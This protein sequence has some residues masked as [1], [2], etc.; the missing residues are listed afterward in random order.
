MTTKTKIHWWY[1][2]DKILIKWHKLLV[3]T[4]GENSS[5]FKKMIKKV[6]YSLPVRKLPHVVTSYV[7]RNQYILHYGDRY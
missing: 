5:M 1:E 4:V 7:Y 3:E 6:T 2:K